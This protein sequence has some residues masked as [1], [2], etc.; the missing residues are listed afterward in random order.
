MS[1][2]SEAIMNKEPEDTKGVER[3]VF[4]V[5]KGYSWHHTSYCYL[6]Y[7]H[8]GNCQLA[9]PAPNLEADIVEQIWEEIVEDL[10]QKLVYYEGIEYWTK[11]PLRFDKPNLKQLANKPPG[12]DFV[13][14]TY[15]Q[16]VTDPDNGLPGAQATKLTEEEIAKI[17]EY[18]R[19]KRRNK[20]GR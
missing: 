3:M 4:Q 11:E 15:Y 10:G 14:Y 12:F 13:S 20:R 2:K 8:K 6:R 17:M 19:E 7:D 9:A 1:E 5:K 18:R 16:R